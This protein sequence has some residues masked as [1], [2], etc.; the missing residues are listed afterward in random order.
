MVVE[1]CNSMH[2]IRVNLGEA[3][4]INFIHQDLASLGLCMIQT[5]FSAIVKFGLVYLQSIRFVSFRL[6]VLIQIGSRY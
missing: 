5:Q 3:I 2:Y 1:F 4:G 6:A